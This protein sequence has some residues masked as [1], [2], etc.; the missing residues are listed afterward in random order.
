MIQVLGAPYCFRFSFP[1]VDLF[2]KIPIGNSVR[3]AKLIQL[4]PLFI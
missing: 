4:S 2:G 3:T 1:L